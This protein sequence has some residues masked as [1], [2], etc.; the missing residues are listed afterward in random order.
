M[1]DDGRAA[2]LQLLLGDAS[3]QVIRKVITDAFPGMFLI[4][5]QDPRDN[6]ARSKLLMI[7]IEM[8]YNTAFVGGGS[9]L[10]AQTAAQHAKLMGRTDIEY[11]HVLRTLGLI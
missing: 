4:I 8:R 11:D 3:P 2:A 1:T 7:R 6:I 10:S 5:G 9:G